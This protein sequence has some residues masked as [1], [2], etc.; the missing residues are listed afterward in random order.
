VPYFQGKHVGLVLVAVLIILFGVPYTILLFL[1]QWLV[2]VPNW[3]VFKWTR[4]TKLNAFISVHHAPYNSKYRYWTGLLLLVRVILYIT[5]SVATSYSNNPQSSLLLTVILLG[6]LFFLNGI[7]GFMAY[8]SSLVNVLE[9]GLYF[10]L[11]AFAA[12][13]QYDF[14][15]NVTK[16]TVVAYTSTII[17]FILLVGVIA[18]HVYLQDHPQREEVNEY[19]LAP[20]QPAEGK[21]THSV[22]EI[23]RLCDQ[24]PPEENTDQIEA[25]ERATPVDHYP[26]INR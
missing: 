4:N 18:Y 2:R 22:V 14:R 26:K 1:W 23:L 19:P 24:P 20:V 10:N 11:L 12:F 16:Q 21:V 13:S 8:K 25:E 15:N 7:T 9:T 6:G 17:T 5:V 3:K